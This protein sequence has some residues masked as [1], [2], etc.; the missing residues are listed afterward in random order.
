M[1][2]N[3]LSSKPSYPWIFWQKLLFGLLG[4]SIIGSAIIF[5]LVKESALYL[6]MHPKVLLVN[7]ISGSKSPPHIGQIDIVETNPRKGDRLGSEVAEEVDRIAA[8]ITVRITGEKNNQGSGA[9]FAK[10]GNKY[11][12]L[13]AKHIVNK[14]NTDYSVVTPDSKTYLVEAK[15]VKKLSGLDLAVLEFSSQESYRVATLGNY[16]LKV[17]RTPWV[18]LSG[19][20]IAKSDNSDKRAFN[21]GQI[22]SQQIG[23]LHL[24]DAYSLKQGYQLLY[25]N[26]S[27]AGMSGGPVLDTQGR[28]IGIHGASRVDRVTK[29]QLGNSL[30]VP[31]Q[32]FLPLVYR[33][34]IPKDSLKV[35]RS[36]P[37]ELPPEKN[38]DSAIPA[39]FVLQEPT[40]GKN[41][42]HWVNYG[43]QLWRMGFNQEAIQALDEAIKI[44]PDF[45][46]AWYLRG[47][48]LKGE[49]KY[50]EALA[51]FEQVLKI[52]PKLYPVLLERGEVFAQLGEY[53]NALKS[54][55]QGIEVN[56]EN[57]IFHWLR[58]NLLYQSKRYATAI[59]AYT[60]GIKI[61]PHALAYYNRAIARYHLK[62]YLGAIADYNLA[63]NMNFQ[64]GET[65]FG[66][67][68][69]Y[70]AQGDRQKAIEDFD[71]AKELF[72]PQGRPEC[73]DEIPSFLEKPGI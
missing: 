27:K 14:K 66:R 57:I 32:E 29:V 7:L 13:T 23:L 28:V 58:G 56:S 38:I 50:P 46:A 24:T 3:Y 69:A 6:L 64:S 41:Y 31:I 20:P 39:V 16:K 22:F 54:I 8:E 26:F 72:C 52:Q 25:T 61:Q 40:Q 67:G 62:D 37:P 60:D 21:A 35:E 68:L 49:Q 11:Y 73:E 36:Q 51:S 4:V 18:F 65:Y 15:S 10:E 33:F 19:W 55:E 30:G 17:D 34:G 2:K 70:F 43:N 9:I 12:V 53:S 48:A 45:Y 59:A 44:K 5:V 42:R 63:L 47:L 1:T 71:K